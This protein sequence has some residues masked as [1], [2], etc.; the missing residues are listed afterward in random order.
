MLS[1][2]SRFEMLDYN[3]MNITLNISINNLMKMQ[4]E[5]ILY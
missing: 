1:T 2:E 5:G 4:A 3:Y